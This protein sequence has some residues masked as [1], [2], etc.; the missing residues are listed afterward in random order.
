MP[1][2]YSNKRRKNRS[3]NSKLPSDSHGNHYVLNK[4]QLH[5]IHG[6]TTTPKCKVKKAVGNISY[7]VIMSWQLG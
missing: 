4:A 5:N 6:T 1:S 3:N 2:L 7:R